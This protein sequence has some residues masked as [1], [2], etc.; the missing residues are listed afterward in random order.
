MVGFYVH[1]PV[2]PYSL[3]MAK[4][5]CVM[6]AGRALSREFSKLR[7]G[8]VG[9]FEARVR[10]GVFFQSSGQVLCIFKARP[11]TVEKMD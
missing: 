8:Q 3:E 7:S 6:R 4:G 9:Y 10:S 11:G 5:R 1:G 2:G